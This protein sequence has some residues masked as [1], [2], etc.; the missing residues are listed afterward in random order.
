VAA[1]HCSLFNHM[2]DGFP[3]VHWLGRNSICDNWKDAAAAEFLDAASASRY[4]K[5]VHV[6]LQYSGSH[7]KVL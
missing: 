5:H 3:S 2:N 4:N 1:V 7:A 6:Y